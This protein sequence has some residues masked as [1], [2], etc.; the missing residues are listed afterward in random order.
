[1]PLLQNM[2]NLDRCPHCS[3]SKPTL[4]KIHE[5]VTDNH[6]GSNQRYWR[7]EPN[8]RNRVRVDIKGEIP[9]PTDKLG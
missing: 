6:A 7:I 2:L 5:V 8:V 4:E 9:P 3:V 1:M